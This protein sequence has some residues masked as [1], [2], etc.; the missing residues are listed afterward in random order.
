MSFNALHSVKKSAILWIASCAKK[1][2][3]LDI[4]P[5]MH[6]RT[7]LHTWSS[8]WSTWDKQKLHAPRP[9]LYSTTCSQQSHVRHENSTASNRPVC[10]QSQCEPIRNVANIL[11]RWPFLACEMKGSTMN[12][13]KEQRAR[14][15]ALLDA[16]AASE[17]VRQAFLRQNTSLILLIRF[18]PYPS[19]KI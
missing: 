10:T 7:D 17:S 12:L 2:C 13:Y 11:R 16:N 1:S 3:K 4:Y 18:D 8:S 6:D 14:G 9:L 19:H 15:A 5:S